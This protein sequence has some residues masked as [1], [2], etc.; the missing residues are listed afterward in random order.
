MTRLHSVL[1]ISLRYIR[2]P[3][4]RGMLLQRQFYDIRGQMWFRERLV[5]VHGGIL[6]P[7]LS[8][9]TGTALLVLTAWQFE[10][11]PSDLVKAEPDCAGE[12]CDA[13]VRRRCDALSLRLKH[14]V[15][16]NTF[17]PAGV[18]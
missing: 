8:G 15:L 12:S 18:I 7:R 3:D 11:R 14:F 9:V 2:K 13:A 5:P 1:F 16:K 17:H 4:N 6:R 10:L